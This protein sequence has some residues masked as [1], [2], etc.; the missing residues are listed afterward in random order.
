MEPETES[1]HEQDKDDE[2]SSW[3]RESGK[4]R[5]IL[6]WSLQKGV[7]ANSIKCTSCN[8][9]IHK[10][11]SGVSGKLSNMS[12]FHCTKYV[13]CS[14]VRSEELKKIPESVVGMLRKVQLF[15]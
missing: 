12:N 13:H 1:E 15:G 10:K 4:V 14:S 2:V 5:K 6:V 7:V 3:Y 9:W 8:S 11:C